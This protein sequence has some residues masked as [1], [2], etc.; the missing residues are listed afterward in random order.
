[1]SP[2]VVAASVNAPSEK[3]FQIVPFETEHSGRRCPSMKTNGNILGDRRA[4]CDLAER[5]FVKLQQSLEADTQRFFNSVL[6]HGR[7][8]L[9][10]S[11][12]R[13]ANAIAT[14][15]STDR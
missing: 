13:T 4:V 1:M 11:Q 6:A 7:E 14:H 9:G 5:Y 2:L 15:Q 12:L 3:L 8:R 10:V